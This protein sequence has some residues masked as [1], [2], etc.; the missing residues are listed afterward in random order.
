VRA[1][2]APSEIAQHYAASLHSVVAGSDLMFTLTALKAG[3]A[4]TLQQ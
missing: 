2:Y 1:A 3:Y 4:P